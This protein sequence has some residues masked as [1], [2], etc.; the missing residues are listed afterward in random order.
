MAA[1]MPGPRNML[2][3]RYVSSYEFAYSSGPQ[4]TARWPNLVLFAIALA[5]FIIA[6]QMYSA[7]FSWKSHFDPINLLTKSIICDSER[8]DN[9]FFVF[10]EIT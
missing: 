8:G 7:M 5:L 2:A 10:S 1:F 3:V 9:F 6:K 4:S